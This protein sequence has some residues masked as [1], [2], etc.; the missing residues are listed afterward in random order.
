MDEWVLERTIGVP[1]GGHVL[2]QYLST[3]LDE[4]KIISYQSQRLD[5]VQCSQCS[6]YDKYYT[7]WSDQKTI[8]IDEEQLDPTEIDRENCIKR[9]SV[10]YAYSP[11]D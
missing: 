1:A 3:K 11:D 5:F 6:G 9:E 8:L 2:L 7:L 10:S 4:Y